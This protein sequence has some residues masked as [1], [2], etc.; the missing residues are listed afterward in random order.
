M[1]FLLA[2]L[3]IPAVDTSTPPDWLVVE[4]QSPVGGLV[5][6]PRLGEPLSVAM[7]ADTCE[8]VAWDLSG[9]VLTVVCGGGGVVRV[10]WGLNAT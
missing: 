2:C 10:V 7:C 1:I 4:A 9:E 6:L 3:F 8:A 5:T